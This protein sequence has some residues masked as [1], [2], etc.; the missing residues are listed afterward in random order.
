MTSLLNNSLNVIYLPIVIV[1]KVISNERIATHERASK[2]YSKTW[3][4]YFANKDHISLEK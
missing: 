4:N 1:N 2:T 3:S